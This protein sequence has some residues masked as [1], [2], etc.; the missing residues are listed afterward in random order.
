VV[1]LKAARNVGDDV[2]YTPRAKSAYTT[3][4]ATDK[5]EMPSRTCRR[6]HVQ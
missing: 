1:A 6:H 4:Q 5:R 2:L 3:P